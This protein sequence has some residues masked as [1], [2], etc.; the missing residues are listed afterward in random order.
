MC[1]ITLVKA[2]YEPIKGFKMECKKR[3]Q[4]NY[5]I[6]DLT[7]YSINDNKKI[8]KQKEYRKRKED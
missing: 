7:E 6:T 3:Y 8:L 2:Q 5:V 1:Y 4:I